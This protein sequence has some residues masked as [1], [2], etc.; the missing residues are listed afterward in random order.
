[1]AP[2]T[3][4]I[5]GVDPDATPPP[6]P[7]EPTFY[8]APGATPHGLSA[9]PP[10][11]PPPAQDEP[12]PNQ[13][14]PEPG[15]D[16]TPP[17]VDPARDLGV[18]AT[19]PVLR[20]DEAI[21]VVPPAVFDVAASARAAVAL[22][23]SVDALEPGFTAWEDLRAEQKVALSAIDEELRRIDEQ[24]TLLLGAMRSALET[25]GAADAL[26]SGAEATLTAARAE[27][28]RQ[29]ELVEAAMREAN[30]AIRTELAGRVER[31]ASYAKP[32]VRLMVRGLPEGRRILHLERPSPEDAVVLL[33]VLSGRIPSRFGY[34]FDDSVE[35]LQRPPSLFFAEEGVDVEAPRSADGFVRVLD[36]LEAVWPVKA[37]LP[38]PLD[39]G[40][41]VV[42]RTRGAVLEAELGDGPTFRNCLTEAEAERI[43]ARMLAL[44]FEGRL[45][46]EL[47]RG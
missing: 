45:E 8:S 43:V 35:D 11:L 29:R 1:M 27:L 41:L 13:T 34:L 15:P 38:Q 20:G 46:L 17:M 42:W 40:G 25:R 19:P 9:A 39:G 12:R 21:M 3:L 37:V 10:A 44:K 2:P 14:P 47:G 22:V 24:G 31:R 4:P 18:H 6:L 16:A 30:Q 7:T 23:R 36:G 32:R 33:Q 26:A 5:A 28:L